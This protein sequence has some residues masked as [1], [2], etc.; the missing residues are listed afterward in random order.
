MAFRIVPIVE[1]HGEVAALPILLR[2]VIAEL[3]PPIAIDIARP[4]PRPKGSLLK[5]GGIES[6]VEFTASETRE[7]GVIL[8]L[9]DSDGDCP[10][11]LAAQLLVRAR[12][13]RADKRIS[14]VVTHQEF[15]AWFLASAS[16]LK[17][18][19]RLSAD[20]IDHPEPESVHGCKEWLEKWLPPTSKYSPNADQAALTATFDM[21]LAKKTRSFRKLWKEVEGICQHA[22]TLEL[23]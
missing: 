16:S 20:M 6:A 10:G 5:E 1:G 19:R 22:R 17:G 7:N 15:E 3:N 18:V 14:V 13:A 11:K 12:E 9:L 8:I 21:T 2:R 4:I 23:T